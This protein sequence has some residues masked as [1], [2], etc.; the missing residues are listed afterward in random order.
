MLQS[1]TMRP[2]RWLLLPMFLATFFSATPALAGRRPAEFNAPQEMT[3]EEL[4]AAKER[5]KNKLLGF[6]EQQEETPMCSPFGNNGKCKPFPWAFLVLA[7]ISFS[8]ASV[9]M[10]RSF[11]TTSKELK[12]TDAYAGGRRPR[13]GQ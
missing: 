4:A 9:F 10:I 8:I 6:T 1:S 5:S 2:L 11:R 12:T 7:G 3:E 13:G